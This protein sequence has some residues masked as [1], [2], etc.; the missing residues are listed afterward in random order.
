M[1]YK[2]F[3]SKSFKSSNAI[4]IFY[5]Y[6]LLSGNFLPYIKLTYL[7]PKTNGLNKHCVALVWFIGI[8]SLKMRRHSSTVIVIVFCLNAI[9]MKEL[10]LVCF[11]ILV[12]LRF[13][14]VKFIIWVKYCCSHGDT[15]Q[16]NSP[17]TNGL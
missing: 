8:I 2:F 7:H 4:H 1:I 11:L 10:Y 16:E 17:K 15:I 3:M 14:Y 12:K 13:N 5:Y 6:F 9:Y